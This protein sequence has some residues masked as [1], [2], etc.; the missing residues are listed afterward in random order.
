MGYFSHCQG[1]ALALWG[2]EE[3][4]HR[5]VCEAEVSGVWGPYEAPK[6]SGYAGLVQKDL[7]SPFLTLALEVSAFCAL[8]LSLVY[9]SHGWTIPRLDQIKREALIMGC[10]QSRVSEEWLLCLQHTQQELGFTPH[11]WQD[12]LAFL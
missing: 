1:E 7:I 8:N 6:C 10:A 3:T 9:N 4:H 5:G 12:T 2:S 11:R